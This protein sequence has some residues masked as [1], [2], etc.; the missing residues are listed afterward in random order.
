VTQE[1]SGWT[2]RDL[3]SSNGTYVN[4]ARIAGTV[5]VQPGDDVWFGSARFHLVRDRRSRQ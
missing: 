3:A 1:A 2:L 4:G 5:F